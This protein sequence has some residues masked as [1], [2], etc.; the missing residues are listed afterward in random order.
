MSRKH[1]PM[2][3][4]VFGGTGTGK[5]FN[6]KIV[7]D[8]I[9]AERARARV[10]TNLVVFDPEGGDEGF[11]LRN[12]IECY[13]RRDMVEAML[14]RKNGL[15]PP[16][17]LRAPID[18]FDPRPPGHRL[19]AQVSAFWHNTLLVIDE[20]A[21]LMTASECPETLHLLFRRGR[22]WGLDWIV[23]SQ[24]PR[25][26]HNV[27]LAN[28]QRAIILPQG[29]DSDRKKLLG[30]EGFKMPPGYQWKSVMKDG[31]PHKSAVLPIRWIRTPLEIIAP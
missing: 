18:D 23:G 21:D 24:R 27:V 30:L 26:I 17:V 20:G 14:D 11:T 15:G 28:A 22:K 29:T 13:T 25:E 4:C 7:A 8:E 12:Q 16:I 19:R 31:K 10:P 2:G 1:D 6:L 3:W 9:L 5:T